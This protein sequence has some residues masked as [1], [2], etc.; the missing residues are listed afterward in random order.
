MKNVFVY[1]IVVVAILIGGFYVLNNYIYTEKQGDTLGQPDYKNVSYVING[2]TITLIDGKAEALG[3]GTTSA[4]TTYFGNEIEG[5]FNEDGISDIA[6]LL[7]QEMGGSGTFYYVVAALKTDTGYQGT[8]AVLLGDR[9]A[10]QSTETEGGRIIVNYATRSA[11]EPMTA[12]P[13]RN[14]T[15]Y[16]VIVNGELKEAD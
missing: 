13:T 6:F 10:P 15:K 3:T 16:F 12:E 2:E 7:A 5:D 14:I 8:N 1:A 4:V 11:T 9:I